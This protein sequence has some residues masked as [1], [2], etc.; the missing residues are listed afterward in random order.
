MQLSAHQ[1]HRAFWITFQ[2]VL[3][4]ISSPP[5]AVPCAVA[6]AAFRARIAVTAHGQGAVAACLLCPLWISKHY[7]RLRA[8]GTSPHAAEAASSSARA[9]LACVKHARTHAC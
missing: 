6:G 8:D 1:A 5:D 3:A 7:A 9:V 4:R 2:T